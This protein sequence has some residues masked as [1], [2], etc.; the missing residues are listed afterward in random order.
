M[1]TSFVITVKENISDLKVFYSKAPIH[2]RPRY[3]MLLL[4]AVGQTSSQELAAKTGVSRNTIAAWKRSYSEGGIERLTSDQRGGDFKSNI[5]A[6]DK[7]KIEKKLSNPKKAFTSFSE[8]QAWLKEELGID[9]K[10]HAVNKYLKRNFG[11][12]LKVGRKSH[13]KKDEAAVAVFKKHGR[14]ARTY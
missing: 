7:K 10:Y 3:K 2:L 13:V 11:A 1:A 6:D 8:A 12:K 9:K 14:G 5:S 4:I